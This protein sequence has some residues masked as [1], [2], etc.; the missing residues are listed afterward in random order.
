MHLQQAILTESQPTQRCRLLD[1]LSCSYVVY[2]FERELKGDEREFVP[3]R[4][5]QLRNT[6]QT[7]CTAS[8]SNK[9][10][11]C[12]ARDGWQLHRE[13]HLVVLRQ[14]YPVS[15]SELAKCLSRL[16]ASSS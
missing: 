15:S 8:L 6:G 12:I 16:T 11:L 14:L 10:H 1:F 4:S 13:P 7:G 3:K 9:G 2:G 5:R